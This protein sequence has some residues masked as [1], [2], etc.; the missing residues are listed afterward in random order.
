M[1]SKSTSSG[2]KSLPNSISKTL[3]DQET[4]IEE[5]GETERTR[6]ASTVIE[7]ATSL[8]TANLEE[9][10]VTE[11]IEEEA[12]L[13]EI[14]GIAEIDH[15][16]EGIVETDLQE[17]IETTQESTEAEETTREMIEGGKIMEE[18]MIEMT[19]EIE[20]MIM[21][22]IVMKEVMIEEMTE[23][24]IEGMIETDLDQDLIDVIE[25]DKADHTHLNLKE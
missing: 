2:A 12:D 8:E 18:D 11:T 14:E 24:T 7:R 4:E 25:E 15:Q 3:E 9:D 10:L 22:M 21:I 1:V 6:N 20:I 23:N 17:D 5:I 13:P 16:E 19:E